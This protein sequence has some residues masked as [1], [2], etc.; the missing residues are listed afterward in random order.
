MVKKTGSQ[1]SFRLLR[2][3]PIRLSAAGSPTLL[4]LSHKT[5]EIY[6]KTL[7][8]LQSLKDKKPVQLRRSTLYNKRIC[9]NKRTTRFL[10]MYKTKGHGFLT[11]AQKYA[12]GNLQVSVS[13]LH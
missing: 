12:C 8:L 3:P 9:E 4:V 10:K 2:S 13:E 1:S 6:L 7:A 11:L 5:A